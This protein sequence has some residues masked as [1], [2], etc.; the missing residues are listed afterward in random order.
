[1]NF[2]TIALTFVLCSTSL[3]LAHPTYLT[4]VEKYNSLFNSS[5]PMITMYTSPSCGPCMQMKP[6]FYKASNTHTDISF[7]LV[8]INK[9]EMKDLTQRLQIQSIPT[10]ILSCDG[11]IIAR[12]RGRLTKRE[13]EQEITQFKD[14]LAQ[15]SKKS[16]E[17]TKKLVPSADKNV[18]KAPV[19]RK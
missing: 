19:V 15:R 5:K 9:P 1:M 13:L 4:S 7:C 8:E 6:D 17:T 3:L 11:K 10:I 16:Q 2:K 18:K 14:A 12:T